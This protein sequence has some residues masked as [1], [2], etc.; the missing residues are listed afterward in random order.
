MKSSP[1]SYYCCQGML[2][3]FSTKSYHILSTGTA[4]VVVLLICRIF[5]NGECRIDLHIKHLTTRYISLM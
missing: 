1:L 3:L 5:N 4:R 2:A